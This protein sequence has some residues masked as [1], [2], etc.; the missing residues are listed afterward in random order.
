MKT[1]EQYAD[2]IQAG[3]KRFHTLGRAD[4]EM[5]LIACALG[6]EVD[7]TARVEAIRRILA[8]DTVVERRLIEKLRDA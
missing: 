4:L 6:A 3:L 5:H 2:E 8:A 1:T 7:D